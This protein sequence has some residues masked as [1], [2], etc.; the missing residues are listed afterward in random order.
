MRGGPGG[1][2]PKGV[3]GPMGIHG[4]S[5]PQGRP[6]SQSHYLVNDVVIDA[7]DTPL[8]S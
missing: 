1:I 8:S 3:A 6:V 4:S 5:G 7:T 2:G